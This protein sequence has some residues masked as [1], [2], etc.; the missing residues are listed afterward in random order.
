MS[1]IETDEDSGEALTAEQVEQDTLRCGL[2]RSRAERAIEYIDANLGSTLRVDEIAK[3][4]RTTDYFACGTRAFRVSDARTVAQIARHFELSRQGVLWVVSAL[5]KEGLVELI[6]NPDHKRSKL[7]QFT[8]RGREI[9][10]ELE[11]R[12]IVWLRHA[13]PAR[14][15]L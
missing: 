2:A 11:R 5:V 1:A 8:G 13:R 6:D 3:T 9:H 12:E 10:A 14:V 4:A 7:V 15:L